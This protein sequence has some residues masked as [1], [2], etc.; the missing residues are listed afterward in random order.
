M[1]L[2]CWIQ[3]SQPRQ[4]PSSQ[5]CQLSGHSALLVHSHW[6]GALEPLPQVSQG[7][8]KHPQ[9]GAQWRGSTDR[10]SQIQHGE[11][12]QSAGWH[13]TKIGSSTQPNSNSAWAHRGSHAG[14]ASQ[15]S[16]SSGAQ[17]TGVGPVEV[18]SATVEAGPEAS[19]SPELGLLVLALELVLGL[20]PSSVPGSLVAGP[21][22]TQRTTSHQ[23]DARM[24][25]PDYCGS[26]RNANTGSPELPSQ[27]ARG[28]DVGRHVAPGRFPTMST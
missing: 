10:P 13:P 24:T 2:H 22:A 27:R 16:A 11:P 6:A 3:S 7:S 21:H 4:K 5:S 25:H 1:Q 28:L 26:S 18:E 23:L 15:A 19:T 8:G 14:S 20:D 12:G 9:L 17:S